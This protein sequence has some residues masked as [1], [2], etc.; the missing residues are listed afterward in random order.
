LLRLRL[1]GAE[2]MA[3]VSSG[4]HPLPLLRRSGAEPVPI[5]Q[6]GSLLGV[7]DTDDFHDRRTALQAGDVVV[8]YTDGVTEGRQGRDF[9]GEERLHTAIVR[10][11]ASASALVD[12]IVGEVLEFQSGRANDDIAVVAVRVPTS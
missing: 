10:Y 1:V 11:S 12:G 5:G 8:L 4:G 2:W 3:T 7:F 9:F 6:A